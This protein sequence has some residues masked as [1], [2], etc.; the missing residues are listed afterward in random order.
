MG[1]EWVKS[2]CELFTSANIPVYRYSEGFGEEYFRVCFH[3]IFIG[4][5]YDMTTHLPDFCEPSLRMI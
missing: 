1:E 4:Q 2:C 5:D 3:I